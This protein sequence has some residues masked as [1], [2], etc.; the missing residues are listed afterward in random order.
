[1]LL[2]ELK[3]KALN[4]NA[5]S[6][7]P[8]CQT[9]N[10][11]GYEIEFKITAFQSGFG[12]GKKTVISGSISLNDANKTSV[13]LNNS[14]IEEIRRKVSK[15]LGLKNTSERK[16]RA[17]KEHPIIVQSEVEKLRQNLA[18]AR[19]LP[20]QWVRIDA[21]KL[22]AAF[23]DARKKDTAPRKLSSLSSLDAEKQL[24]A[25]ELLQRAGLL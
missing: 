12:S 25:Y 18:V 9:L 24:K 23:K 8:V 7:L 17:K 1:M 6:V 16:P 2:N 21:V 3:L 22:R 5:E 15:L 11:E 20:Q 19:R 14:D 4:I 13:E 10:V